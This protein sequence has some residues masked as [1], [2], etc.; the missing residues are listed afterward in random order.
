MCLGVVW[1]MDGWMDGVGRLDF[2]CVCVGKGRGIEY[3][4]GLFARDVQYNLNIARTLSF[5]PSFTNQVVWFI[6]ILN[7]VFER[8]R[9]TRRE[10]FSL[11]Y[12]QD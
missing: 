4:D 6:S 7:I 9:E 1:A 11:G 2:K 8:G 12:T 10:S 3:V 5:P